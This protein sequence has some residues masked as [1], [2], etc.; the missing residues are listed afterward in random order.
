M[1]AVSWIMF[2]LHVNFN[3]EG[4]NLY[5]KNDF[6]N[7]EYL[8]VSNLDWFVELDKVRG[9][10]EDGPGGVHQHVHQST[11]LIL[12]ISTQNF[13]GLLWKNTSRTEFVK[14]CLI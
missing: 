7:E 13:K 4:R 10:K 2:A 5:F 14:S 1:E 3:E 11:R 8:W 9:S 12:H 6:C